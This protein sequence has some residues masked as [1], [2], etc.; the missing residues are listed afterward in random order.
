MVIWPEFRT[1]QYRDDDH[2][3]DA[4]HFTWLIKKHSFEIAWTAPDIPTETW[5]GWSSV[6]RLDWLTS[7]SNESSASKPEVILDDTAD[8]R[9]TSFKPKA[10][11]ETES[12]WIEFEIS[13]QVFQQLRIVPRKLHSTFELNLSDKFSSPLQPGL[14][15]EF[16]KRNT[17]LGTYQSL[18][19]LSCFWWLHGTTKS[20]LSTYRD[21]QNSRIRSYS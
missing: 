16:S 11:I 6:I 10:S 19:F 8:A 15:L 9:I 14:P 4:P 12:W 17:L 1:G 7:G 21:Y 18:E 2:L 5:T 13:F 3:L 20:V